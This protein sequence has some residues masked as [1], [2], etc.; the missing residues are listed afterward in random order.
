MT[1]RSNGP[2]GSGNQMTLME[3]ARELER[4]MISIFESDTDGVRPAH[5]MDEVYANDP[6]WKD[7]VFVLRV[8]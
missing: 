1:L 3:V 5:G 2:T 7:L 6:A 8:L 4:R